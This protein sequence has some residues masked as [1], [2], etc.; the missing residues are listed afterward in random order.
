MIMTKLGIKYS[1][2]QLNGLG[3]TNNLQVCQVL[4]ILYKILKLRQAP[5]PRFQ[6]MTAKSLD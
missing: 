5:T 6:G 2:Y 1:F 3:P 4:D